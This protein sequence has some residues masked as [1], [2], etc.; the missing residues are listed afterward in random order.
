MI[1][2]G[3][4]LAA[5]FPAAPLAAQTPPTDIAASPTSGEI[6]LASYSIDYLLVV[7]SG[8]LPLADGDA[9]GPVQL[10][11]DVPF[12]TGARLENRLRN[13]AGLAQFRRSDARS[14]HPTSQ[15]L[16]LRG[17]GGNA[18]SRALVT[19][20]GVPQADPYGGWV[21]W[22]AYDNINLAGARL[23]R[24]GGGADGPGALA[25]TLSLY[26]AMADGAELALAGGSRGAAD[27]AISI[28]G[29]G[30]AGGQISVDA[31]FARG[32]GFVPIAPAQQ[33]LADRPA[34]YRQYGA[35]L[36]A[37]RD[38]GGN[39][40]IEL[41][42][43]GFADRRDRGVD[44]TRSDI[45]GVDAS[46]RYLLNPTGAPGWQ[47]I[48]LGYVQLRELST[49]FASVSADRAAATPVLAQVVPATGLGM[50]MEVRPPL[51]SGNPLRLGADWR[52]V[53]GETQEGFFFAGTAPQRQRVAGGS[54]DTVGG[55]AEWT[56]RAGRLF[57][58]V[59]SGRID[60]W[61]LGAGS[62]VE[63]TISSGALLADD[64]FAARSGWAG[65]GRAALRWQDG[66][67]SLRTAAYSGW[68]LPT[69]NE[70]YRPFR[71]GAD[72]T[73]ANE[74]L[75]PERLWGAEAGVDWQGG[76]VKLSLTAFANRLD[77]AI[78]NVT[79]ARGPGNFPGVGFVGGAGRFAQRQ[80]LDAILARGVEASASGRLGDIKLRATYAF[81]DARVRAS[82]AAAALDGQ[83]PAQ[84]ARHSGSLSADADFDA[85]RLGAVLRYIGPQNED[86]LGQ[87]VLRDAVTVDAT[88]T[89][90]LDDRLTLEARAENLANALVPAA[91]TSG[92]VVERAAPRSLWLG[93]R[94]RF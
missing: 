75:R 76:D 87:L 3:L 89:W 65:T 81:T 73:A 1:R 43:R 70:L 88:A 18:S 9:L 54:A 15:G 5:I 61:R 2:S 83:R 7:G 19:L 6:V 32:N 55:F 24:G 60:H 30:L 90:D 34:P 78:A 57:D 20:D 62:R 79:L 10:L 44:F 28:G 66:G 67:F 94:V 26:S 31:R 51:A 39:G 84:V 16:T 63:Q 50:R 33:G 22:S 86:D 58:A 59:I 80:N 25:G 69:L 68:R 8:L 74:N 56:G 36:R 35:G 29:G 91:I 64:A 27:A 23:A 92:G 49:G 45:S 46:A 11:R 40:R 47:G 41:G 82:G 17:L 52:R 12:G 42:L 38:V 48:L 93:A 21:A 77:D 72:A 13:E 71:A 37:R 53:V 14:A 85:L 4:A